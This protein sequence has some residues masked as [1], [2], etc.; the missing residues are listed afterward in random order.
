MYLP[1]L[2]WWLIDYDHNGIPNELHEWGEEND[3]PLAGSFGG[4]SDT[5]P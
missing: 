2:H 5:N 4:E 1:Y 3:L